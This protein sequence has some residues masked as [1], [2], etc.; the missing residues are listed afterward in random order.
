M[1]GV[2]IGFMD[3]WAVAAP[4]KSEPAR[5]S[6]T[7]GLVITDTLTTSLRSSR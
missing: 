4:A 3:T 6:A 5:V 7:K 1:T 2:A